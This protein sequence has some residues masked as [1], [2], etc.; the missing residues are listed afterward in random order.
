MNSSP[1]SNGRWLII[2]VEVQVRDLMGR[3]MVATIAAN[4]G[5]NVL[6]GRDQVIRRLA[7][8]LPK[9]ILFDKALGVAGDRKIRRYS[10]LGFKLTAFDEESTGFYPNPHMAF[11]GR[12]SDECLDMAE[13]WFCLS[14]KIRELALGYHPDYGEKFVTTGLPR[15]DIWRPQFH[16]L[17]QSQVSEIKQKHGDFIL[18]CSNFGRIIHGMEGAF[19]DRQ[20]RRQPD[21]DGSVSGYQTKIE[22]QSRENLKAYLEMLPQLRK[23]YPDQKLVVRPHP[24]ERSEFWKEAFSNED[25][26]EVHEYGTA[27]PWI[28]ASTCLVHHGCTTG[29]EAE[30]MS[31]SHV[32]YAPFPDSHHDTPLMKKFAT[33]E[34]DLKG[35]KKRLDAIILENK[36]FQKSRKSLEEYYAGLSGPLVAER[37]VGEFD[38][39]SLNAASLPG[40]LPL[41]RYLPRHLF[42]TYWPR[43]KQ[44]AAYRNKKYPGVSEA[45]VQRLV[46]EISKSLKSSNQVEEVFPELFRVSNR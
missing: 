7:P 36:T 5:Y 25:G 32:M 12:L 37:I 8:F 16:N 30:L 1:N 10:R 45:E 14:D 6:I 34:K 28:L 13:R 3:L 17:F 23:W 9:G 35:L 15:S 18:F 38:D 2:P 44:E 29:I 22:E 41:L 39:I 40:Y 42:A 21:K 11:T 46:G 26:V 4:R 19:V 33:I 31:K 27:T 43:S 20:I 24:S